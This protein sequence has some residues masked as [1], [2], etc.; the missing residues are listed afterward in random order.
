MAI[1]PERP[2]IVEINR[3]RDTRHVRTASVD[4]EDQRASEHRVPNADRHA[5]IAYGATKRDDKVLTRSL[6]SGVR[7][8]RSS[9]LRGP[10]ALTRGD[11]GALSTHQLME[12]CQ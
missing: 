8:H 3:R 12:K 7:A 1:A 6:A 5:D 9:D 10:Y 2:P 4:C 11:C